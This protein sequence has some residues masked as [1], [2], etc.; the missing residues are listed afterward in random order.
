M[1]RIAIILLSICTLG[2][3]FCRAESAAITH[4]FNVM[5]KAG[6]L[7]Y[8]SDYKIGVTNE[9]TY[10][11]MG[12]GVFT[13]VAGTGGF[14]IG[15]KLSKNDSVQTSPAIANLKRLQLLHN[16]GS[17]PSGVKIYT[18]TDNSTWTDISSSAICSKSDIDVPITKGDYY[19][20]VVN[21]TGA[22]I[23]FLSF[24][25]IYDPCHC[26]RVVSE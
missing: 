17:V 14:I 24:S 20:K 9:V 2:S 11:C 18:S 1:K 19:I 5:N 25:Y 21:K 6:T 26:L 8:L 7:T 16:K 10:T 15:I 4:D 23:N 12:K 13:N 22:D 3:A